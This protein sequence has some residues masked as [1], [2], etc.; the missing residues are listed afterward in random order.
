MS[1]P[2]PSGTFWNQM[3]RKVMTAPR[4]LSAGTTCPRRNRGKGRTA[5]T[6][7]AAA[8]RRLAATPRWRAASAAPVA[9]PENDQSSRCSRVPGGRHP[10]GRRAGGPARRPEGAPRAPR[11]WLPRRTTRVP[12]A[13]GSRGG[14]TRRAGS[15]LPRPPPSGR[16]GRRRAAPLPRQREDFRRLLLDQR[17]AYRSLPILQEVILDHDEVL[18]PRRDPGDGRLGVRRNLV[19]LTQFGGDPLSIRRERPLDEGDGVVAVPCALDETQ[20]ADFEPRSIPGR[21]VGDGET[22]QDIVEGIVQDGHADADLP[23]ARERSGVGAA[24]RVLRDVPVD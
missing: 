11:R 2:R 17:I 16:R 10:R 19:R 15:L 23:A 14:A 12:A 9:P 18:E 7:A 8:S 5:A 20:F 22:L 1:A 6:I 3:E 24:T 4:P 21:A 13:P